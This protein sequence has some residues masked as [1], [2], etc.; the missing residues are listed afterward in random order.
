MTDTLGKL[1]EDAAA[2]WLESRGHSILSRNWRGGRVELDIVSLD[3]EGIHFVEVKSRKAPVM[4][5]PAVN[6]DA[7]KRRHL[8]AAA[9]K[10]LSGNT[11]LGQREVFF[12]ILTVV[13]DHT[14]TH[15][16][17][18]PQAFIPVYA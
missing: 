6:V 3:P 8:V 11:G 4:A 18:Y 12:D 5:D 13:F 9:R 10:W 16:N 14:D 17:Y 7:A 15:I 1:G 2:R